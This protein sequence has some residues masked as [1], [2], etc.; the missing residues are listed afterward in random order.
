MTVKLNSAGS[1][2]YIYER[3][4]K[5]PKPRKVSDLGSELGQVR[6]WRTACLFIGYDLYYPG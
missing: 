5:W 6:A 1:T 2:A 3:S 4:R